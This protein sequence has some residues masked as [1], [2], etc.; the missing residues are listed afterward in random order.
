[1]N[2]TADRFLVGTRKGLFDVR[3]KGAS[4]AI[5]EPLLKGQAIANAV[6][7]PR[8]RSVWASIDHGHWGVK[9]SRS[10][11][12]G[13][14]FAEAPPPKYPAKSKKAAKY[15]WCLEPGHVTEPDTFWVGTEPGGLFETRDDGETWMLNKRLWELCVKDSWFGGGRNEPGVHSIEIDPRDA[16]RMHVGVS[17]GGTLET[18]DGGATWEYRNQGVKTVG[19]E[20]VDV[21]RLKRAPSEPDVLWQSNHMGMWRSENQGKTW[22]DVAKK[23]YVQFGFPMVVHPKKS[24]VAWFVP[25]DSDGARMAVGGALVVMKTVNGGG[26]WQQRREG[27]PQ[28]DAWDF[29]LRHAVDVGADGETLAMGTTSGN[30]YVS[31]DGGDSWKALSRNLPLIYSVRFA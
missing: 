6:R 11:N 30:L 19:P 28:K 18:R 20:G 10:R 31:E 15:Y 22:T 29:P 8:N 26:T 14:S 13:K 7:D 25:M 23:P 9:L 2:E 12:D 4:W 27:L 24:K 3:R 1:V 17:C 21:H 5:G 16:R